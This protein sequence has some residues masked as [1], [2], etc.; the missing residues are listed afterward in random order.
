MDLDS[1]SVVGVRGMEDG[2]VTLD[3]QSS[4]SLAQREVVSKLVVFQRIAE[5]MPKHQCIFSSSPS[6]ILGIIKES[7]SRVKS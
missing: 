1:V 3:S 4:A 5:A 6:R 2:G 7:S